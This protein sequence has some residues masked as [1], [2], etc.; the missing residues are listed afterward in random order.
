MRDSAFAPP[1]IPP[2][3]WSR[4]EVTAALGRR[5]IGELFRLLNALPGMSQMRIGA[6][7]GNA[8]GRVSQIIH[9]NH[10]VRTVKS[11]NRIA[12]GLGM[13]D[14]ARTALGLAP[15]SPAHP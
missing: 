11:L 3:F 14:D 15:S 2:D 6:A 10:E 5:D 1:A 8:Q 12:E 9:G 4:S 13:P 7:T